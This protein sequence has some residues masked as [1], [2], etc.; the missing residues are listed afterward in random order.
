MA[1]LCLGAL[2]GVGP[3]RTFASFSSSTDTAGSSFS[4]DRIFT[5]SR[6]TT[7]WSVSDAADGSASDESNP[8]S[9]VDANFTTTGNWT[10]TFGAS[11]YL[12]FALNSP[13]PAGIS[14]SDAAFSFTFAD[15]DGAG[16]N[17]F[18]YYFEVR[19]TSD[20]SV[21]ATHGSSGSPVACEA[22]QTMATISTA[23]PSVSTTDLANDLTIRVFGQHTGS[24]AVRIDSA[25]V[26]GTL[27]S[28]SFSLYSQKFTD[29][30]TGTATI[31][32][33]GP[34]FSADGTNYQAFGNWSNAFSATRYIDYTFPAYVPGGGTVT[35]ASLD[36][37]Y[38]S[39]TSGD[40]T[41]WY[42]EVYNNTTLIGSHGSSGASISC[43]AATSYLSENVAMPEINTPGKA[44]NVRVR[45]YMRNTGSRRSQ[46]DLVR[47][48]VTYS[49][50][51]TGCTVP[52]TQTLN[53]AADSWTDQNAPAANEGTNADL[54]VRAKSAT[55]ARRTFL[56]FSLPTLPSGCTLASATLRL[57]SNG[58]Q[59]TRT[60]EVYRAAASWAE[61]TITWANQPGTTGSPVSQTIT[62]TGWKEWTVTSLVQAQYSGSNDGLV[63]K[64]SVEDTGGTSLEQKFDSRENATNKPELIVTIN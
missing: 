40:N 34:A 8:R 17:Q 31:T 9:L 16:G 44:N 5:G 47:L 12:E 50:G 64:D 10:T 36:H 1:M 60:L 53:P 42:F 63:V 52:G 11:R 19:K 28:N 7:A 3:G 23:I 59:G 24:K 37:S 13:L 35:T 51:A 43:N 27:Y 39:A 29:S 2:I 49:M 56:R 20:N 26:T 57:N 14:L 22:S 48:N 18:C 25:R 46:Q 45:I 61:G 55:E 15:S 21:L 54:K 41:C 30:S 58:A 4:A 6:S 62:G 32:P 33:W 38:R